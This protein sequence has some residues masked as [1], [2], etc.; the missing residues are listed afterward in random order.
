MLTLGRWEYSRKVEVEVYGNSSG[1]TTLKWAVGNLFDKIYKEHGTTSIILEDSDGNTL[2]CS[3][4][5]DEQ[6]DWLGNMVI[7]AEIISIVPN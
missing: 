5:E 1:V 2:K 6:E 3:D 7:A 4:D